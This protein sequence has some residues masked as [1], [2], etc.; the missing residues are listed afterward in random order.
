MALNLEKKQEIVRL[1]LEKRQVPTGI[2][3]AVKLMLDVSGSMQGMFSNGAVQE[4]VDRLIPVAMR[5]DDNQSLEAYAYS[6]DVKQVEDIKP[7]DFG[8]YIPNFLKQAKKVLWGGTRYSVALRQLTDDIQPKKAGFLKSMFGKKQEVQPP[9]FVMFV[10]DGDT[11]GDQPE[12]DNILAD[13]EDKNC[14]VMLVG[15]GRDRFGFLERMAQNY[16]HVGLVTFP[17]LESTSDE[18]M[19]NALLSEELCAWIKSR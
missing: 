12:T 11:Q 6:D 16:A 3:M 4:L 19:Y 15:I 14:Y 13:L 8:G 5:F 2:V 7:A 10:T 17:R 1:T 18:E 9:S